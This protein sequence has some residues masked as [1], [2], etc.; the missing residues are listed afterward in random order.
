MTYKKLLIATHNIGKLNEFREIFTH[1]PLELVSLK[2]QDV[3]EDVEETGSTMEENATLKA[4]TYA[5]LCDMLTLA[6][7]SGLEVEALEGA[8]GPFSKRYAGPNASD[9]DRID[10]LLFQMRGV[11]WE[12]RNAQFRSVISLVDR[13]K[14]ILQCQGICYGKIA[15]EP[16]G[17]EG[18]GYD[19]IFYLPEQNCTMAE[20]TSEQKNR[21]SH[22]GIAGREMVALISHAGKDV[23]C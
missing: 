2:D 12:N 13:G 22:R 14:E 21:I 23:L 20:L 7:D 16:K 9:Q 3:E 11:P 8:P 18:F 17:S 6:D 4:Q 10:Y 19:P 5:K 1:L 15:L